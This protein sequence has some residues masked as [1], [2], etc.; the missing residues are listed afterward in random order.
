MAPVDPSLPVAA[1]VA[2]ADA[3]Y[4]MRY[5][6]SL[7]AQL[8]ARSG[9]ENIANAIRLA[10]WLK[11]HAMTIATR[12]W[13]VGHPVWAGI[14]R[15]AELVLG[16]IPVA[17]EITV[18][19]H[20]VFGHGARIREFGGTASYHFNAPPPYGFSPSYT[21]VDKPYTP[22][23]DADI[24]VSQAG[25]VVEGHERHEVIVSSFEANTLNHVDSGLLVGE[26]IHEL[27]E[28]T[29]PFGGINDVQAWTGLI[30]VRHGVSPRSIRRDYLVATA[31]S[32]LVNPTFLY[33]VYDV[34]W[35]FLVEG[36]R[37][38]PMP[39]IEIGGAALWADTHVSPTPWGLQYELSLLGRWKDQALEIA[40]HWGK[41]PG[42]SFVG[43]DV[44][45]LEAHVTSHLSVGGG[46]CLWLQPELEL[47]LPV[48][49]GVLSRSPADPPMRP[50]GGGHVLMRW[51]E[52]TWFV[53]VR[54]DAKT[55]G[56]H[57]LSPIADGGELTALVGLRLDPP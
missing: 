20:E 23:V 46:I 48:G 55:A 18:I 32:G 49:L 52:E 25:I 45:V 33:G 38:G 17:A 53:G 36:K 41:G 24:V 12:K 4:P 27:I 11:D 22:S 40:P 51:E 14:A 37:T 28:A 26:P 2:P 9:T 5:E 7:D 15:A 8:L 1:E 42:G 6:F 54:G 16:D 50:G 35:R 29:M 47:S 30:A 19:P 56:L 43:I 31:V 13:Q 57:D 10:F 34:F 21:H 3:S 44:Q 39:S